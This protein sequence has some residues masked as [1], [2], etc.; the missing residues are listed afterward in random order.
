MFVVVFLIFETRYSIPAMI[1]E[2]CKKT[3]CVYVSDGTVITMMDKLLSHCMSFPTDA[4]NLV[5]G[6]PLL[7]FINNPA[8]LKVSLA[9]EEEC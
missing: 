4:G 3:H 5:A 1:V 7:F 2:V 6:W 8:A 9:N